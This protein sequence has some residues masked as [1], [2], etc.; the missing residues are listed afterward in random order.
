MPVGIAPQVAHTGDEDAVTSEGEAEAISVEEGVEALIEDGVEVD[1]GVALTDMATEIVVGVQTDS[2]VLVEDS[3]IEE[4]ASVAVGLSPVGGMTDHSE[5]TDHQ[6]TLGDPHHVMDQKNTAEIVIIPHHD[7]TLPHLV[8]HPPAGMTHA[9]LQVVTTHPPGIPT[10]HPQVP[11][12]MPLP[13]E[14]TGHVMVPHQTDTQA[15]T[16]VTDMILPQ[17]A[18]MTH[19]QDVTMMTDLQDLMM[20]LETMTVTQVHPLEIMKVVVVARPVG[21]QGR[22]EGMHH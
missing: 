13:L 5:M 4:A 7:E 11:D 21:L 3:G 2:V 15:E 12:T 16:M 8:V 17:V 10:V 6:V 14:T 9:P 18:T 19:H 20:A 22:T 1:L